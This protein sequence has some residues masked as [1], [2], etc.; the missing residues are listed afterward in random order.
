MIPLVDIF[1]Y[2]I[3]HPNISFELFA[4]IRLLVAQEENFP[5][6]ID[7][8]HDLLNAI[9]HLSHEQIEAVK[10]NPD[11]APLEPKEKSLLKFVL[12]AVQD[13]AST[14]QED[15]DRLKELG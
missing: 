10:T 6:C 4:H 3:N 7:Y 15:I 1:S 14:K 5:Y 13:P 8:N 11:K 9:S 12:K 2:F